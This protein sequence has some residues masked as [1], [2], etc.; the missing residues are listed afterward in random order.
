MIGKS[1][2]QI[3]AY[4]QDSLVG[5]VAYWVIPRL[6]LNGNSLDLDNFVVD[7]ARRSLGVGKIL[8]KAIEDQAIV[9]GCSTVVLDTYTNNF[10]AIK[11]YVKNDYIQKGFHFVK[12]LK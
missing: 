8:L 9:L 6:W 10:S 11:F 1:Y 7:E 2:Q 12:D 5:V 4:D 3:Q